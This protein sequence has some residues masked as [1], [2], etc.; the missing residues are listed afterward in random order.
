MRVDARSPGIRRTI[1]PPGVPVLPGSSAAVVAGGFVFTGSMLAF[2]PD[3]RLHP[4]SLIDGDAVPTADPIEL[5]SAVLMR[6]LHT[7]LSAAGSDIG[8]DV[9]RIWQWVKTPYPSDDEYARGPIAWPRFPAGDGYVRVAR[10][11]LDSLRTSTGIGVK[12]LPLA[13]GC[14]AVEVLAALPRT[15]EA[16][17]GFPDDEADATLPFVSTIRLGDWVTTCAGASDM[18]GDWKSSVHLGEPSLVAVDARVNPYIWLGS[19]IEV[20][21]QWTLSRLAAAAKR[22]GTDLQKC[23]Y[24]DVTLCDPSDYQ[25]FERIWRRWFPVDPPAR[26][27]TTGARIVVKGVRVEIALLLS[28][29]TSML[30]RATIE[31]GTVAPPVGHAPHAVRIGDLLFISTRLPLDANCTVPMRLRPHNGREFLQRTAYEQAKAAL[32]SLSGICDSAGTEIANV[33]KVQM[34]MDDLHHLPEVLEAWAEIFPRNPPALAVMGM[35]GGQPLLAPHALVQV[36]A[37]AWVPPA[38]V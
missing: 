27:L 13:G 34:F 24:A 35:G 10:T 15:D 7:T 20:Q 29:A 8:R 23:V 37:I 9:M 16:K 18:R 36:D 5:Q 25:G 12:E 4:E 28:S 6:N 14:F 11:M 32:Q 31:V 3:L 17:E 38:S 26:K 30:E 19:E 1:N 22:A 33:C 2:G 21:T